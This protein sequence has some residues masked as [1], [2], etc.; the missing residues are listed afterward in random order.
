MMVKVPMIPW[1]KILEEKKE[2]ERK[3]FG[4][5]LQI[6]AP[7]EVPRDPPP[8]MNEERGCCDITDFLRV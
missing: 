4:V 8:Q 6:P 5:P 3:P 7:P 1:K 2:R